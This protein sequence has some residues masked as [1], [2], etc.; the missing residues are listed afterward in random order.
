MRAGNAE[1]VREI[2]D[3]MNVALMKRAA[4]GEPPPALLDRFASD[5]Q[6]DMSRRVVNPGI[7][8]G[9][10]GLRRFGIEV[11]EVWAQFSIEPERFIEA[12]DRVVVIVTRRGRGR[13]SGI[14]VED[15]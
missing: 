13:A 9:H 15:R 11:R 6:I 2:I 10:A 3:L 14:E 7:Y 4:S 8:D 1:I 12:G 5:V